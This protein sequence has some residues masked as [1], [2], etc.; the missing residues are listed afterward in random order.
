MLNTTFGL[1]KAAAAA[2]TAG[3]GHKGVRQQVVRVGL[4]CKNVEISIRPAPTFIVLGREKQKGITVT[5]FTTAAHASFE[6][7]L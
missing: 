5:A 2:A 7:R 3:W 1:E 4:R 6:L